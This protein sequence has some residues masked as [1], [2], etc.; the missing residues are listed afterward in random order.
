MLLIAEIGLTIW[1]WRRGWKGWALLPPVL[2]LAIGFIVG[3]TA[4][5]YDYN[6]MDSLMGIGLVMDIVCIIVLII[7]VAVPRRKNEPVTYEP[8]YTPEAPPYIPPVQSTPPII[9]AVAPVAAIEPPTVYAPRPQAKL[10][11]PG[12]REI[13]I[14]RA[15][16]PVGRNDFGQ[17]LSPEELK[18]VSR[19]HLLIRSEGDRYYVEDSNS[20]NRTR[21][22][23]VDIRNQGSKEI[24]DGDRIDVADTLALTFRVCGQV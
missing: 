12:N 16:N 22:N 9:E 15:V 18:Y 4:N 19:Q 24:R 13:T 1:A 21:V 2:A 8:A 10:V 7:M 17:A 3:L 23:G 20:A 5:P 6:A 11:L 14:D